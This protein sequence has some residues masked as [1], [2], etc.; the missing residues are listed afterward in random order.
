MP[1]LRFLPLA[2]LVALPLAAAAPSPARAGAT[3][4]DADQQACVNA[5]NKAFGL[6]VGSA[7]AA[8]V[9][10]L[11]DVAKG[12]AD[13]FAACLAGADFSAALARL[14]KREA[15]R[16]DA[17]GVEPEDVFAYT[18]DPGLVAGAATGQTLAA[19]RGLLGPLGNVAP[20]AEAEAARCQKAMVKGLASFVDAV[21]R[22]ANHRKS[23][24]LRGKDGS[25]ATTASELEAD[26]AGVPGARKVVAAITRLQEAAAG[27]CAGEDLSA[28]FP[29][30]CADAD[31]PDLF[32]SCA[33]ELGLCRVCLALNQ[34]DGLALDCA[35]FS[36]LEECP[37]AVCGDGFVED[38]EGCDDG[39]QEDGDGCRSDCTEES[40]GDGILDPNEEC[41]GG[42]ETEE[43][44]CLA[45]CTLGASPDSEPHV[46]AAVVGTAQNVAGF[47]S[48]PGG[49]TLDEVAYDVPALAGASGARLVISASCFGTGTNQVEF[50]TDGATFAC[51]Q[52][53][54]DRVVSDATSAGTIFVEAIG[55]D[56][57]FVQ[58]V[59]T[60]S[61]TG[62]SLAPPDADYSLQIPLD[63]TASATDFVSFPAGDTT[64]TLS[65]S[66]T[67][68]NAN[69][70][71]PGGR[72]RLVLSASCFGTGTQN[73]QF[74]VG[75]QAFSCGQ[76]FFDA[77]VTAATDDRTVT[78][79]AVAGA[80]TFV[81]WV[82]TGT[83]TPTD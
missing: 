19:H 58:W 57:T 24:S 11:K 6:A 81:Q 34:A 22:N 42:D 75:G 23:Q 35:A 4:L 76:T 12:V 53:L 72:A 17:R 28:L 68:M 56:A 48:F 9:Q 15:G 40:C 63:T 20:K 38:V 43:D 14:E 77:E 39:N 18:G 51:G 50:T 73:L 13:E 30:T 70:D 36:G 80:A 62:V 16:C 27:R 37:P 32:A 61:A 3:P 52:T 49:D 5:I 1:A 46:L 29:G 41:D 74:S 25:P 55:G 33:A 64:D 83:A 78:I 60:A 8:A 69:P 65:V 67:G 82:V 79:S 66:V 44:G 45:D 59:L 26:L 7:N 31:R 2:L 47:V 10:C 21:V 71:L 54:V